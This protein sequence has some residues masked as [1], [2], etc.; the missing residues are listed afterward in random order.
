MGF[1][2]PATRHKYLLHTSATFAVMILAHSQIALA[3][4]EGGIVTSGSATIQSIGTTTTIQQTSDRAII[5]WD[6]FD[7]DNTDHVQFQQ[8]SSSSITVNR[9]RDTKASQINGKITANGNI[10]L[11]NPNGIVFGANSVVD[12]GGIVAT[13]SDIE[14][15]ADFMAGGAV[16]FTKPGKDDARIINHG[17]MTVRDAGL[18]GLVAPHIENHGVIQA[19]MGRVQLASGDMATIDFAGDGLIKLEVSDAV[20]AQSIRNTGTLDA[21]GGSVL[22]TAAQARGMVDALITNTGTIKANTLAH[23]TGSVEIQAAQGKIINTGTIAAAGLRDNEMGGTITV[24]ADQIILDG[25]AL[26]DASGDLGG[27]SIRVGGDYQGGGTLPTSDYLFV[28]NDVILNSRSRK[29]AQAGTIIL[30]SDDTTRFYGHADASGND[31]LIEVSGKQALDF[32]GT[33]DLR[34]TSGANGTLLLDPTNITI[35][36]GANSNVTGATPYE[37][38]ADS[39]TS[40]LNIATLQTALNNGNV[41]VQTRATG[42]QAGNITVDSA[43]T[44]ANGNKLTLDAHNQI[45]INQAISGHDLH[46]IAGGD[47]VIGNTLS[48]AGTLTI[49]QRSDAITMGLG[50]GVGTLNL[51]VAEIANIQNGW[52]DIILGRQTATA[53]MTVNALTWNDNLTLRSGTGVISIAGVQT[54]AAGN[55]LSIITDGDLAV[56][57]T[58][59]GNSTGTLR[60]QQASAGTTIGLGGGAGILN[61][62]VTEIGYIDG[63]WSNIIIGRTDGT[64]AVTMSTAIWA[65]PLTIQSGSG[66]INVSGVQTMGANA[67]T[68]KTDGDITLAAVANILSGSTT[69]TFEQVSASTG[70]GLGDAMTG[71]LNLTTTEISRLRDGW[72]NI[73]FGRTDATADINIGTGTWK[74]HLTLLTGSGNI[75]ASGLTTS[76][77]NLTAKTTSGDITFATILTKTGGTSALET[78]TG[79]IT[80]AGGAALGTGSLRMV[81]DSDI[82]LGGDISG[83]GTLT[84]SQASANTSMGIGTGQA[85]TVH[86]NDTEVT[87]IL[88]GWSSRTFGRAD[89]SADMN[90][91]TSLW[92]DHLTLLSG[93]G[94]VHINGVLSTL[95]KNLT[96]TTTD[97]NITFANALT[98]TSGTTVLESSTGLISLTHGASL[99]AGNLRLTTDSNLFLGDNISGTGSLSIWQASDNVSMGVGTGQAGTL[100]LDDDE[101]LRIQD[102][103]SG[104]TFGR[105]D[106]VADFDFIGGAWADPLNLRSGTGMM[107]INGPVAMGSN[108][109]TLST[110][111]N[112]NLNGA[113]TISSNNYLTITTNDPGTTIG[114]GDGQ[115][116]TLHLSNAELAFLPTT[117]KGITIGNAA[118]TGDMNIGTHSW[119]DALT[120]RT[121][122]GVININGNQ[123]MAA[124]ALTFLT[125]ADMV[126]NGTLSGTGTLTIAPAIAATS[127]GMGDGQTGTMTFSNA[128]LA[129]FS[130]GWGSIIIGTTAL[131]GAINM[132]AYNWNSSLTLRTSTGAM[133]ILGDQNMGAKNL[134]LTTGSNLA[135]DGLLTGTGTLNITPTL[136]TTHIGIGDGQAGVLLLSDAE[137]DRI[138]TGWASVVIGSTTI[139]NNMNIGARTWNN[140]MD[141]RTDIGAL[142]I[143]GAQNMGANNLVLRTNTN[144]G[145]NYI[146]AGTGTLS[147]LNSGTAAANSIG[148]GDGQ[149]GQLH[150]SN[151]ELALFE[152][153]GWNT[154]AFGNGSSA[155]ALNVAAHTWGTNL[156]LRNAGNASNLLNINGV[157]TMGNNNLTITSNN[158]IVIGHALNGTGTLSIGQT[159]ATIGMGVGTGQTGA[160]AISNAELALIGSGWSELQFGTATA[161]SGTHAAINV[162]AYNWNN[163]VTFRSISGAININGIQDTGARNFTISTSG[164]PAINAA[165]NGTGLLR[166]IPAAVST[167]MG[168]GGSGTLNLTSGEISN[169]GAGWDQ[170]IFGREDG[171]G[172]VAV[173]AR[174]WNNDVVVQSGT[175]VITISGATMGTNDLTL[176]TNGNLSLT[177]NLTGTSQLTIKNTSG[178]AG[179]SLGTGQ[180]GTLNLDAT[181]ITRIVDG[182]AGVTIGSENSFG[183]INI[184][185]NTWVN[186]MTFI[187][188]GN[189][190]L[191]GIQATTETG[192]TPLVFATTGGAFINNVGSNA[193]DPG[194]GRY[195]V[196]SVAQANDT[197]NDL[198]RPTIVTDQSYGSYGPALVT[199]TG[200]VYLYSGLGMKILTLKINDLDKIYGDANPTYLYSYISGLQGGDLLNDIVLSYT[201][202]AAGSNALDDAGTTRTITGTFSLGGGYA[203]NL[204]TGTLTVE[205]ADL[206]V[207]G[208][209]DHRFYGSNNPALTISYSGFKNGED[210]SELDD[211]ATAATTAT[212]LSNVGTYAITTSGGSDNNYNYIYTDGTLTVD[213]A[214]LTATAQSTTREY[215]EANPTFTFNY[216]GFKNGD[217]VT[218]IDTKAT[219]TTIATATSNVGNYAITGSGAVDNNYAFTYVAGTLGVTKATV[220]ATANNQSRLYG[221]ANPALGVSYS[222]FK[223]GETQSVFTTQAT[224]STAAD[225]LSNVNTYAITASGAAATNYNFVYNNGTLT[226]NKATLTVTA[227]NGLRLYGDTN[228]ALGV[229]YS[230]FKN[231]QTDSVLTTQATATSAA[232]A[233]SDVGSYATVASGAAA[234]NYDFNYVNG[235]FTVDKASLI[236]TAQNAS[237]VYGE[238]NPALSFVYTGFKNGQ[239]DTVIDTKAT[240]ATDATLASNV[241]TYTITGSGAFDNNYAFTYVNGTLDVTKAT[242]TATAN[243]KSRLYGAVNPVF[244]VS[245]TGFKGT[246]TA[247]VI[248]TLATASTTA[249]ALSGVN[250]Y[251]ITVTGADDN[252]YSFNYI[253]GLLTVGKALITV[254]S[255][256]GTRSYG[257][258]NPSLNTL[259]SG[260]RNSENHTVL[261]ALATTTSAADASSNVGTYATTSSGAVANNYDFNY[262]DG[263]L[264]ITKATLTATAGNGTRI[265]GDANPSFTV[266]Y[267]GFKNSDT[268]LDIDTLATASSAANATSNVGNYA[269]QAT[270]GLDNNYAFNYVD[271]ILNIAKAELNA[272]AA[273]ATRVAGEANPVFTVSYTGFR[274]GESSNVIDTLATASTTAG[275]ATPIGNYAIIAAGAFDNN[276]SFIYTD[277]ILE[278]TASA[279]PPPASITALPPT[280]DIGTVIPVLYQTTASPQL[281]SMLRS[282]T[283]ANIIIMNNDNITEPS[284]FSYNAL[285]AISASVHDYFDNGS[286]KE[287]QNDSAF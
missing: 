223:N 204:L 181:E 243:N 242:L 125:S 218:G 195:L 200:N 127:I 90:I 268:I 72:A 247:S 56:T 154:I 106:S 284:L 5:G 47:I 232:D 274:N 271:G 35:S 286:G 25:A 83:T 217:T 48:G 93:A 235:T 174:T 173:A 189:V 185:A 98:K 80:L 53:N 94:D 180:T 144:L 186:P 20:A 22:I 277:G 145:I 124:N 123:T 263:V 219:G 140:S 13:S 68:F 177:G 67:L 17:T 133:N 159:A 50:G 150:L 169:F 239:T 165:I 14:N 88:T 99:G 163:N 104:I 156:I 21:E 76:A 280:A 161:V 126:L 51:S 265:Y 52:A 160:V 39:V 238:A 61:L 164:N 19:K 91:G 273:N 146:L 15:D 111:S 225:A 57:N 224:A 75:N 110:D 28:G 27:G 233:T 129:K 59:N 26:I 116:G 166:I 137:L 107:N 216:S 95:T 78:D 182:W 158:D 194:D 231:G 172:A 46:M 65:D 188:G 85:G 63:N 71:A 168:I 228:P 266:N 193:I 23:K 230:G 34:S 45:I 275:L 256:D 120:L 285:I 24:L 29:P 113:I 196:Y 70:I 255:G 84:I 102:G 253:D 73:I 205:K 226:V 38:S 175:G 103:W 279:L 119:S 260:F 179:I 254:T 176:S 191:N 112:L 42:A 148:I 134:T 270:G 155:G 203:L 37:P 171:T 212:I 170:I 157:Q 79:L 183:N 178:L 207:E 7:L 227:G 206:I 236:A 62:S 210:E 4:P 16:K 287:Q 11:L 234:N 60:I 151:A 252:N 100:H 41:I 12:V 135:I 201:M 40:V 36:S 197:L 202:S 33:V 81:T 241:G 9:I 8:P 153:Q 152:N 262:V 69:L 198:V 77:N 74:D 32:A 215:G 278:I 118:A 117:S 192:G 184:G 43:I 66:L 131:T 122:T 162:G 31:G 87:R 89:G 128:D 259:Y 58:M 138:Q 86:L 101:I 267:A 96:I 229:S 115:A 245:Y 283:P 30:W 211:L 222:G 55:N 237:R 221:D 147:I 272:I 130:N 208:D 187:T 54:T 141:F 248:D 82:V 92:G 261:T 190:I 10:I 167:T 209:S 258:A 132:G 97:G 220:S 251:A 108:N 121:G 149:T 18:A 249:D 246:D 269:T 1:I 64:G 114:L 2:R 276:Y 49:E 281:V 143:N 136:A 250:D 6:S 240:G 139:D 105:T 214:L 44:W 257:D 199:E 213:K 109:L 142:N 282:K 3:A 244:D 264:T